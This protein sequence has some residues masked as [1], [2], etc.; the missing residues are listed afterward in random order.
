MMGLYSNPTPLDAGPSVPEV[1]QPVAPVDTTPA[2][3]AV[4]DTVI[5][6]GF[7]VEVVAIGADGSLQLHGGCWFVTVSDASLVSRA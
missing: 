5:W 1:E 3:L 2:A 7:P 4:G 6:K